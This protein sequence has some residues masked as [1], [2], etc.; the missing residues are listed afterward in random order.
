MTK[1]VECPCG[2]G[3]V[4]PEGEEIRGGVNSLSGPK[5]PRCALIKK[6]KATPPDFLRKPSEEFKRGL[7]TGSCPVIS[8]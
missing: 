6:V 3:I 4:E 8:A 5:T 2:G 1:K 7:K